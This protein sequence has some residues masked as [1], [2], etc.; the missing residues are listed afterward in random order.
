MDTLETYQ[1]STNQ[2]A[3]PSSTKGSETKQRG[4]AWE[5]PVQGGKVLYKVAS[6]R[7]RA[8]GRRGHAMTTTTKELAAE[9]PAT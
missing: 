8:R 4:Y 5:M 6:I 7:Q 2:R 1:A 3:R 9:Q